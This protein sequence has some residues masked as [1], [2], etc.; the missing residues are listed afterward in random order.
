MAEEGKNKVA[1][2]LLDMQ[3]TAILEL[4]RVFPDRINKPTLFLGF[5]GGANFNKSIV[6]QGVKYLP[7]AMEGEGF[8]VLGDGKLPR[9]K[10]RIANKN[11]LITNFLQNYKDLIHAKI[12]RKKVQ[13]KFLDDV[14]FDGGNPFGISDPKAEL[15]N[16]T[17][18]MGRKTQESKIFVEFE[19]NS[20]LDLE[21]FSVNSRGV[22]AKYCPWQYRGE[23]CRYQGMPI[24]KDD[25]S[26]FLDSEGKLIVPDYQSSPENSPVDF[27]FDE[28]AAWSSQTAYPKSGIVWVAS[29]SITIRPLGSTDINESGVP[30]KTV[31]ISTVDNNS[32][33]APQDNPSFWLKDGCSK[34]F[35]ACQ[36][37]FTNNSDL[38]MIAGDPEER[39][40]NAVKISGAASPENS[41]V[42]NF[43][44]LFHTTVEQI[45]GALDPRKEWTVMG[46]V[47]VQS[48]SAKGAGIFSTSQKDDGAWPDSRF[49]NIG[50][51]T[52]NRGPSS[53]GH[54]TTKVTADHLGYVLN[55]TSSSSS[56][57]AY[58]STYLNETQPTVQG[59]N[60]SWYQYIIT[61]QTGTA[62]FANPDVPA[63]EQDTLINFYVNG[64]NLFD[65]QG[66]DDARFAN[67]LGNFAS[68]AERTGMTWDGGKKA[69]PETFM[70]G[71]VEYYTTSNGYENN[72]D[73]H[74]SS[75]NG[76]LLTWA[77]WNRSLNELERTY[78]R[79][80]IMTPAAMINDNWAQPQEVP[81]L[82][83]D[84]TG[85]FSTL[86]GGTGDGL[87]SEHRPL[88]YAHH[89]L[90][91]WWDA[92]TGFIGDPADDVTGMLDI[93]TGGFHL[94]G[95][96][97]F[98]G[99]SLTYV[100]G[101]MIRVPNPTP[102][103]PRYGGFPG[104]DGF[105]YGRNVQY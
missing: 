19:L 72:E 59:S 28:S 40:V 24:E 83:E 81:R 32:G 31:Y 56:V 79:K 6:W 58:R 65:G 67:N 45:T 12:V 90:V 63:H 96:G 97:N 47:N 25:G 15:G 92:T 20:P 55:K 38:V 86:T 11:N 27:F 77:V 4:F 43:T 103:N 68:Y 80:P 48:T 70:L 88:S 71:A 93:H 29:P 30:L 21:N 46:W 10:I 98:T 34:K 95:S 101:A 82:Y 1:K 7:I 102:R 52:T 44:G 57:N 16:E 42:P 99:E 60:L 54:K 22:V 61:H 53:V 62:T 51:D 13:V 75:M 76:K 39:T 17:W 36:K 105:G 78:L 85:Q 18:L 41:N 69:L 37:R 87:G 64:N 33:N 50:V 100:E 2:S 49:V 104:T 84:C 66:N 5:H 8:D 74:T 94:T 14:N 26:P 3:P 73:L 89:S 23:G 9:P 35:N 91:A